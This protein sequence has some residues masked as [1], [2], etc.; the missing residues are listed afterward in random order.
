MARRYWVIGGEYEDADFGALVAGTEKVAG[1]F[2]DEH[3]ART[4]WTRLTCCPDGKATTR[5]S[6][7]AET[8]H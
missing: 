5:Y 7:A 4:E 3:R 8:I 6:I 1:P 2:A